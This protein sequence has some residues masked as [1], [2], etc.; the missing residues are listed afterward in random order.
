MRCRRREEGSALIEMTVVLTVLMLLMLGAFDL[1]R[2]VYAYADINQ[3][4]REVARYLVM[5]PGDNAGALTVAADWTK[6]P[7]L[8]P[9]SNVAIVSIPADLPT[10]HMAAVEVTVTYQYHAVSLMIVQAIGNEGVIDL[11]S[12]SRMTLEST[13]H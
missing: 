9:A 2:A 12:H 11:V 6:L 5:H 3:V 10:R 1:G 13:P 8:V 7:D 4:A